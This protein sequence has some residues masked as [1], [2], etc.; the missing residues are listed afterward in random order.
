MNNIAGKVLQVKTNVANQNI[1]SSLYTD[2]AISVNGFHQ[3][4][5]VGDTVFDNMNP[6]GVDYN[7]WYNSLA[8]INGFYIITENF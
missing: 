4:I 6:N 3:A 7:L 5:Q 2:A 8:A 1:F